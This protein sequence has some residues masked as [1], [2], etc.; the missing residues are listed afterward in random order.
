MFPPA[1][2][3]EKEGVGDSTDEG[4]EILLAPGGWTVDWKWVQTL[5]CTIAPARMNGKCP[6]LPAVCA[7]TPLQ[8][9]HRRCLLL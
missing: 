2:S 1:K 9:G 5:G 6:C 7:E 8:S 4:L 3:L